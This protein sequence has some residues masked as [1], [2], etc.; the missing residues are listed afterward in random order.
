MLY[1][2]FDDYGDKWAEISALFSRRSVLTGSLDEIGDQ[3]KKGNTAYEVDDAFLE[4]IEQWRSDLA[5]N[6]AQRNPQISIRDI[7]YAVQKIIDRI[8]FLRICE[9][10]GIEDYGRLRNVVTGADAYER[11][12][13]LFHE[14]D[15]RY[16]SGLFHFKTEM[17]RVGSADKLTPNLKLNDT[18]IS[19]IITNLYYPDSPYEFS[20]LPSDILGQVYERFLGKTIRLTE[21]HEAVIEDKPEVRKAGGVYYTPTYIVDYIVNGTLGRM[22]NGSNPD[23]PRPISVRKA[24]QLKIL[25]PAC[26]SGSFLIKAFQYL[27]DWHRDQYAVRGKYHSRGKNPKVYEAPGGGWQLTTAEKKR[28]LLTSIHGVDVDPQAVE[29]TKLSLLLKVLEGETRENL[30]RDFLAQRERI[31]PDL[32]NNIRCGNS[33]IGPDY[34]DNQQMSLIEEDEVYRVNAFC[35]NDGF[36]KILQR[37]G[38][39]CVIGNPPWGAEFSE[40]ELN[41][42]RHKH[43]EIVVR[44][45][46]S[47]MYFVSVSFRIMEERGYFGMIL[48]DVFLYQKDNEKLRRLLFQKYSMLKAIN[49]GNVFKKVTRPTSIVIAQNTPATKQP[50]CV[51]DLSS[52]VRS[53]KSLIFSRGLA[54]ESAG[55]ELF[56]GLP[57][58]R[59]P[60]GDIATYSIVS[61]ILN[62][63]FPRL[64]SLVDKDGIQRGASPDL[65]DAFIVTPDQSKA[66]S[67]ECDFLKPVYT[68]GAHVKRYHCLAHQLQLIY[69]TRKS[70]FSRCPNICKYIDSLSERITCKEVVQGKHPL[71]SLHRPRKSSIF[72]KRSKIL[73]VITEDEII[74]GL[75]KQRTYATDGLYLFSL[76]NERLTKYVMG[77]LNSR[78]FVF[79]YRKLAIEKGRVLAQVKPTLLAHLPIRSMDM[80][81]S[82][83]KK[84]LDEMND[85][86]GTIMKVCEQTSM[87]SNPVVLNQSKTLKRAIDRR[88]DRIVYNIYDLS[89]EDVQV[90]EASTATQS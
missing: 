16:N 23:A 57:Q 50:V 62:S 44:M 83:D 87:V 22:L 78:L 52:E 48:P 67:L 49:A 21:N 6:L 55:A 11:M 30:Q 17:G 25:D 60:T 81:C 36:K 27:L 20:V 90:I 88:I 32:G 63:D 58:A 28:I 74:V 68:G 71:Y 37:G 5:G 89:D 41:Y 79:L 19:E 2:T 15:A 43:N 12:V 45:I 1:F 14:A 77:I 72:E 86:V 84:I 75:D 46:D 65:K 24:S 70:D 34:Y 4:E 3:S 47:F 85:L 38:F 73:G 64:D 31:L 69:T 76:Q 9:D 13:K 66:F 29:V 35:W 40:L 53:K 54:Y 39:D 59:I 61:K 8:I 51:A 10:R 82:V 56:L 42:L 33:L 80:Q 18:I 7:N 26:G